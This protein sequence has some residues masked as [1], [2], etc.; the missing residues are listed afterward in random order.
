VRVLKKPC[1]EFEGTFPETPALC[2]FD[3][4]LAKRCAHGL[5]SY[6]ASNSLHGFLG[7]WNDSFF[8]AEDIAADID[9]IARLAVRRRMEMTSLAA[10]DPLVP[11]IS[12]ST[13]NPDEQSARFEKPAAICS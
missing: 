10:V 2:A 8:D 7:T 9:Q 6:F 12:M 4:R 5:S 1:N 13:A 11:P 3:A